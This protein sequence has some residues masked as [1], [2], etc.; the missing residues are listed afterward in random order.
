MPRACIAFFRMTRLRLAMLFAAAAA[1]GAAKSPPAQ[2]AAQSPSPFDAPRVEDDSPFVERLN[3]AIARGES[4][5]LAA[6]S[7]AG[8]WQAEAQSG[9]IGVT[10]L[11]MYAL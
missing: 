2:T 9:R 11:A 7:P 5:L 8:A 10:E 6:Q 3:A 1:Q 4:W